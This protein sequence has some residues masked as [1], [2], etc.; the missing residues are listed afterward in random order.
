[1][2]WKEEGEHGQSLETDR[3]SVIRQATEDFISAFCAQAEE[4]SVNRHRERRPEITS[5]RLGIEL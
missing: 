1:M 3:I 4:S 5:F 2:H